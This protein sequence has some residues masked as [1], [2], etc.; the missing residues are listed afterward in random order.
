[1]AGSDVEFL[2]ALHD[3]GGIQVSRDFDRAGLLTVCAGEAV[4]AQVGSS[5]LLLNGADPLIIR[6]DGV[7]LFGEAPLRGEALT[8]FAAGEGRVPPVCRCTVSSA[9][10]REPERNGQAVQATVFIPI[11]AH[12]C[13]PRRDGHAHLKPSAHHVVGKVV[14]VVSVSDFTLGRDELSYNWLYNNW[15]WLWH[16]LTL[17]PSGDGDGDSGDQADT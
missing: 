9:L 13:I 12:A 7:P 11:F 1:M 6:G 14:V 5:F 4:N 15:L 8:P 16:R 10:I 17:S 2:T 3:W